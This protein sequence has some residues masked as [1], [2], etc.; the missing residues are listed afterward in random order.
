MRDMKKAAMIGTAAGAAVLIAG[1]V[2]VGA[3]LG[4]ESGSAPGKQPAA[5]SQSAEPGAGRTSDATT[6]S[7]AQLEKSCRDYVAAKGAAYNGDG[8]WSD[9]GWLVARGDDDVVVTWQATITVDAQWHTTYNFSCP[10]DPSSGQPIPG[11]VLRH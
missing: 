7:D 1:G 10:V 8:V 2:W 11:K 4:G 9:S 5:V 3:S 6:F